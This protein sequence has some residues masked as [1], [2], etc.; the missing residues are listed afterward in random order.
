MEIEKFELRQKELDHTPNL[1][2][3]LDKK[4]IIKSFRVKQG[5]YLQAFVET[6]QGTYRTTSK[7]LLNQLDQLKPR[8][9]LGKGILTTLKKEKSPESKRSY[10]TFA[11]P[12]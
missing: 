2:E 9:D 12:E 3:L 8:L 4:F 1:M 5:A 6:D 11:P 10:Y 7:V